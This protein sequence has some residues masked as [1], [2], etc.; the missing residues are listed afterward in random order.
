MKK[1]NKSGRSS[2]APG[3]AANT[4]KVTNAEAH[5]MKQKINSAKK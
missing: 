1:L 5:K 3:D 2:L 4:E